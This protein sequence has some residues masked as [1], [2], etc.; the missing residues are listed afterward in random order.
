MGYLKEKIKM[1]SLEAFAS[2]STILAVHPLAQHA[3]ILIL[4]LMYKG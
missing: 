4:M 2:L 1:L 3:Y